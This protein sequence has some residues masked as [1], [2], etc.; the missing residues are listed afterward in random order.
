MR[1]E[2]ISITRCPLCAQSI[3]KRSRKV[4]RRSELR[5]FSRLR[6]SKLGLQILHNLFAASAADAFVIMP[7][8]SNPSDAING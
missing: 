6:C 2:Y 8:E 5:H 1:F 7:L 4:F 3:K